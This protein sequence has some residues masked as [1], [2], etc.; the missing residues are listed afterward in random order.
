MD[1]KNYIFGAISIVIALVM[2]GG[3]LLPAI[4]GSTAK[5][6]SYKNDSGQFYDNLQPGTMYN[7]TGNKMTSIVD[8]SE[9]TIEYTPQSNE[10]GN[11]ALFTDNLIISVIGGGQSFAGYIEYIIDSEISYYKYTSINLTVN[12]DSTVTVNVTT[13]TSDTVAATVPYTYSYAA[14]ETGSY[15]YYNSPY[16]VLIEDANQIIGGWFRTEEGIY[17]RSEG[18][19]TDLISWE[20][21]SIIPFEPTVTLTDDVNVSWLKHLTFDGYTISA[22]RET[23]PILYFVV[24]PSDFVKVHR[25][26]L[27]PDSPAATI[28]GVLPIVVL[29]GLL[30]AAVYVFI[31]RK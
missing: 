13:Q 26:G 6:E 25:A 23:V 2:V 19:K 1:I 7:F 29:A 15:K 10:N 8:G 5:I 24:V 14:A 22:D 31:S 17:F 4:D 12:N 27:L 28:L 11:V 18:T 30:L 9:W 3:A 16:D 20:E 21:Q